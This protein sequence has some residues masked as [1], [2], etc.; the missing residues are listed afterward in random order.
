MDY[1]Q[2][3]GSSLHSGKMQQQDRQAFRAEP[4]NMAKF[5]SY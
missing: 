4:V 1:H 3:E 2:V 5:V